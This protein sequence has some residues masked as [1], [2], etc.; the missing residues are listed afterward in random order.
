MLQIRMVVDVIFDK[1][2]DVIDHR[3]VCN[4]NQHT[5][6]RYGPATAPTFFIT[7][8][9]SVIG[10][11]QAPFAHVNAAAAVSAVGRSRSPR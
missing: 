8:A 3:V 5:V 6:A 10:D 9:G 7:T 4:W 2:L 1:T 11:E